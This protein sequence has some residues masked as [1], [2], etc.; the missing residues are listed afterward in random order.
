MKKMREILDSIVLDWIEANKSN[1][2]R[3]VIIERVGPF[4]QLLDDFL[5]K[6]QDTEEGRRRERNKVTKREGLLLQRAENIAQIAY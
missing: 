2:C 5:S 4:E 6:M 1:V 3:F